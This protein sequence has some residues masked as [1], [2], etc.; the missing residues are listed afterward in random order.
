MRRDR[1]CREQLRTCCWSLWLW[2][3]LE[4]AVP[5]PKQT[6]ERYSRP[7][8]AKWLVDSSTFKRL[9]R[10]HNFR[11]RATHKYVYKDTECSLT[12]A[13]TSLCCGVLLKFELLSLTLGIP[14]GWAGS[15]HVS[16]VRRCTAHNTAELGAVRLHLC[17]KGQVFFLRIGTAPEISLHTSILVYY[18]VVY[19]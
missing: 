15:V 10:S 8:G 19:I 9:L 14:N 5:A 17:T 2:P 11:M 12:T 7:S 1:L 3:E 18:W 16:Y 4:R 6:N 13:S